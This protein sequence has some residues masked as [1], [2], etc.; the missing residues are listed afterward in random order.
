M[1]AI[2]YTSN[3][4]TTKEY[5]GLLGNKTSLPVYSL[6]EAKSKVK[7]GSDIIY[8]GWLMASGV[9]GLKE[10]SKRYTVCA[11]C[12]VGMGKTGTQL[13]EV[14]KR[15]AISNH[16]PLFTLQGGFDMKKLHGIYKFMMSVMVKTVGKELT[17]K[18]DRT[19]DEDVMLDMILHG[20]NKVSE[21]NLKAVLDWYYAQ[22]VESMSGQKRK[23]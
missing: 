19:P 1:K 3:T 20:G 23:D 14:R 22:G 2:V 5:A 13:D 17:G 10:A 21:E 7:P 11:I 9:K 18:S 15:N 6:D 8:L 4:G 12:A 16:I